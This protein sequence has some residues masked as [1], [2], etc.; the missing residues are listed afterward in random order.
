M[1]RAASSNADLTSLTLMATTY[2]E[3]TPDFATITTAYATS[4]PNTIETVTII[5]ATAD[6]TATMKVGGK[7]TASGEASAPINLASGS[8][9]I[10]IQV[11]A[12]D[13]TVKD[14]VVTV[15]RAPNNAPVAIPWA[16]EV[17]Q[18][19]EQL[20]LLTGSD[21][22]GD[23]FGYSTFIER[24]DAI[25]IAPADSKAL[26]PVCRKAIENGIT[27]SHNRAGHHP[28]RQPIRRVPVLADDSC[29]VIKSDDFQQL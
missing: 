29:R 20:I 23:D 16:F 24:V 2:P 4:V 12:E 27:G 5:A 22:D 13:G 21:A 17:E 26:I 11:T 14:Y 28:G 7:A 3:L 15:T 9:P 18:D 25:V 19:T 6:D 1:T 8:N 10:T